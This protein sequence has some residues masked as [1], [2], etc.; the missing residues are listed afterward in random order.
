MEYHMSVFSVYKKISNAW[1]KCL[2]AYWKHLYY[3]EI[4][5]RLAEMDP[6][7]PPLTKEQERAIREYWAERGFPDIPL[8]WHRFYYAQTGMEKPE[9]VPEYI[10]SKKIRPVFNDAAFGQVWCDKAY[11]DYFIRGEGIRTVRTVVRNVNGRFM[12]ENWRL[13]SME[14]AQRIMETYEALVI[15]PSTDTSEGWRVQLLTGEYNLAE[16]DK[17]YKKNYIV[18][19]PLRQHPIMAGLNP[20]SINTIRV[21]SVLLEDG[22]HVMSA[23]TKVG[24]PGAFADNRGKGRCFIGIGKDGCFA[25]YAVERSQ[26]RRQDEIPSGFAFAGCPVPGY[27]EMCAMIEKA[28]ES[29]PHFGMAFWDVCIQEDGTPVIVEVNLCYPDANIPQLAGGPFFGD[30]GDQVLAYYRENKE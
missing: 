24:A 7:A 16:L 9:F 4:K 25:P 2:E 17:F 12:D 21:S 1:G 13:I 20:S 27:E 14:E 6:P 22:G 10:F 26:Q 23:F 28:H 5:K 15:K 29:L 30:Y 19:I 3:R 8:Y 11:L 18:Q